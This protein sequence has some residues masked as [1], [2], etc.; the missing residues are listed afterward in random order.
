M[1]SYSDQRESYF[2]NKVTTL[3]T[4]GVVIKSLKQNP[5]KKK[6]KHEEVA[7]KQ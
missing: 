3:M 4:K 1:N 2:K 7:C 5:M 6:A